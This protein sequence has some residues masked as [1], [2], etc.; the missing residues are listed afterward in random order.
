ML[1]VCHI[2][3]QVSYSQSWFRAQK[4]SGRFKRVSNYIVGIVLI[5]LTIPQQASFCTVPSQLTV[6][7]YFV[8]SKKTFSIF[9]I[10]TIAYSPYIMLGFS[11]PV[12]SSIRPANIN[13]ISSILYC[14]DVDSWFQSSITRRY[15][16]S[17]DS[18]ISSLRSFRALRPPFSVH[19]NMRFRACCSVPLLH[20]YIFPELE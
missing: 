11:N 6:V 17:P 15:L 18:S 9:G 12:F 16:T 10:M 8:F 14:L 13:A 5:A 7:D 3:L 1:E 19:F 2:L 4:L 20:C